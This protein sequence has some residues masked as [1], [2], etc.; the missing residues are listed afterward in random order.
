[1]ILRILFV[2]SILL[3]ALAPLPAR[4][5]EPEPEPEMGNLFL[6]EQHALAGEGLFQP[7]PALL[8]AA[9]VFRDKGACFRDRGWL[10]SWARA[11]DVIARDRTACINDRACRAYFLYDT[12]APEVREPLAVAAYLAL[13]EQPPVHRFHVTGADEPVYEWFTS[14]VACPNGYFEIG[15]LR[16]C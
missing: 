2:A 10:T 5:D 15:T 11:Q 6:C 8:E 14:R 7:P 13:T 4:A 9:R 3:L 16:V 12:I 1:M